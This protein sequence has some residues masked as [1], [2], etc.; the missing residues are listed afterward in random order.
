MIGEPL[1]GW[2]LCRAE[3]AA[4]LSTFGSGWGVAFP[5][6]GGAYRNQIRNLKK[7][8]ADA[9]EDSRAATFEAIR[10]I[11]EKIAI[12]TGM[13]WPTNVEPVDRFWSYALSLSL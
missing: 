6:A 11:V 12:A 10:A 4:S 5:N 7:A 3:A 13:S 8:L 1:C 9:D 2:W